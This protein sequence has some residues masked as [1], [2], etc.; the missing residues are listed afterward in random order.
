MLGDC[1][2]C[3][4]IWCGSVFVF[5][6]FHYLSFPLAF[7]GG[8]STAL[9]FGCVTGVSLG[10]LLKLILERGGRGVGVDACVRACVVG[11]PLWLS[12]RSGFFVGICRSASPS[13]L[14]FLFGKTVSWVAKLAN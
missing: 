12:A 9:L 6:S 1:V 7:V 4:F 2:R 8:A 14:A 5:L 11:S 3:W 10:C 13:V